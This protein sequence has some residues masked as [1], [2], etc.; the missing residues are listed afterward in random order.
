MD[1]SQDPRVMAAVAAHDELTAVE[2]HTEVGSTNDVVLQRLRSGSPPG[3]V[4]V[5][6]R[7][8]AGRGRRGRRWIDDLHGPDGPANL[9]VTVALEAGGPRPGRV[10]LAA[11]LAVRAAVGNQGVDAV[12]K[13]P[14]DVLV[15]TPTGQEAKLAGILCEQHRLNGREV[16][17]IGCGVN[18]D[19]RGIERDT[20]SAR[21]TS[22]AEHLGAPV[23]RARLLADL[24]DRLPVEVAAA[25]AG[26]QA[27]LSGYAAACATLG[28]RVRVE[29]TAAP[30][31]VGHAIAVDPDGQLVVRTAAG[32]VTVAAGD[33][34]HLRAEPS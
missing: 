8:T 20:T 6:D 19:W 16:V 1:L 10:P 9:A 5:A 13:W 27:H 26:S 31:V 25:R 3:L 23:D 28:R 17:L 34:T 21:W 22:L 29:R 11:G 4:V 12:L 33:T 7:Q 24:L 2:H 15:P 32:E 30:A 18:L 14:N